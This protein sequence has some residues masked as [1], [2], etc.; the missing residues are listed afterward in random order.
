MPARSSFS[1]ARSLAITAWCASVVVGPTLCAETT[2]AEPA[3]SLVRWLQPQQWQRDTDALAIELGA[4]GDFDDMHIFAPAVAELDGQFW[5]WYCGSR[6]AANQRVFAMGL[7][8]SKDGKLFE[9]ATDNPVLRFDGGKA[10]VLTPTPLRNP[11]GSILRENGKLRMWLSSTTFGKGVPHTLHETTSSDGIHWTQPSPPLLEHVYCP[12]VLKAPTGYQMWFAD[13]RRRPW[14]VRH[15]TSDDG[16]NW[17]LTER[18]VLGLSQ[19]WEAEI[20]VYPTVMQIEGVYLMWYGSYDRAVRRETTAIG[21]AV[22]LDGINWTKHPQNPVIRPDA[23]HEWEANYVGNGNALR[24]ADGSFRYWYA[25]RTKPP[26]RNLYRAI[27][28]VRWDGPAKA[29]APAPGET[30]Q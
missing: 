14:V 11:D 9:K 27:G 6:G 21:F 29:G 10:S 19:E 16:T 12:S 22:S 30:E 5:L 18:P 23:A 8:T 13:V 4:P 26:F 20:L 25:G 24:M 7:A 28:S 1:N 17:K 15:A 2:A 3:P